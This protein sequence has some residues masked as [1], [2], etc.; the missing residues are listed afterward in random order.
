MKKGNEISVTQF[1]IW[2]YS[3]QKQ[4]QVHIDYLTD[5]SLNGDWNNFFDLLDV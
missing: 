5:V 3:Q 1:I 4:C 2:T